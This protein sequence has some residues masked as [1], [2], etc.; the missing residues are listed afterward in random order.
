MT[1]CVLANSEQNKKTIDSNYLAMTGYSRV[2]R[3]ES[4]KKRARKRDHT[5]F[6]NEIWSW[7]E[8]MPGDPRESCA[9]RAHSGRVDMYE[10]LRDSTMTP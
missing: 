3:S 10:G 4:S 7:G 5:K 6:R 8:R 1:F 9:T 2:R